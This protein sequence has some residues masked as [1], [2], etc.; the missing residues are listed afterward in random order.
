L[1]YFPGF[2]TSGFELKNQLHGSAINVLHL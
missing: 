1:F 2:Y